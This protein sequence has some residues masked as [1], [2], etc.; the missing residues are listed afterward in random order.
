MCLLFHLYK[1]HDFT[2]PDITKAYLSF[3]QRKMDSFRISFRKSLWCVPSVLNQCICDECVI[4]Y[5]VLRKIYHHPTLK[6]EFPRIQR[7][8]CSLI[9][10]DKDLTQDSGGIYV[11]R[12]GLQGCRSDSHVPWRLEAGI[13]QARPLSPETAI[14]TAHALKLNC[15]IALGPHSVLEFFPTHSTY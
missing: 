1:S 8:M 11:H 3:L 12:E 15:F 5:F 2:F 13:I 14:N 4:R 9:F 7:I 10:P 6:T